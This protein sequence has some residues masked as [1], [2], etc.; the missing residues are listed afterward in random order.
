MHVLIGT[1]GSDDAL[2]AAGRA[3][4]ILGAA[5]LVTVLAVGETPAAATAGFESGFAGGVASPEQVDEA[6]KAVESA[7]PRRFSRE[8]SISRA[9]DSRPLTVPTGHFRRSATSSFDFPS[10]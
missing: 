7:R 8:R 4:G 9:R 6:W 10:K 2:E 5:D 1:D 3:L